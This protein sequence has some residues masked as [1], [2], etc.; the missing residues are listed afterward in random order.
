LAI[1]LLVDFIF[2]ILS[3]SCFSDV[4]NGGL[5]YGTYALLEELGFAFLHPLAPSMPQQLS[6]PV[7]PLNISEAPRWYVMIEEE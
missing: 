6:L 2:S 4:E 3:L 7:V 1:D 5:I